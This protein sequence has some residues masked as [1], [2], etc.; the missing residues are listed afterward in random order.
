MTQPEPV[1]NHIPDLTRFLTG[2]LHIDF[3]ASPLGGQIGLTH[4]PGRNQVDA[5]GRIWSRDLSLDLDA[6]V[7]AGVSTL[8]TFLDQQELNRLGAAKLP[9]LVRSRP[10]NWVQ[11][12]IPD[13]GVPTDV[14]LLEWCNLLGPMLNQLRNNEQIL[15]HCAAGLGRSGMMAATLLKACGITSD[16]A[17]RLIRQNRSGTV[18]TVEQEKF[19]HKFQYPRLMD[20]A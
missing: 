7:S 18:E 3:V 8:I 15:L 12:P 1:C 11:L 2:P 4:C 16:D 9:T 17:I 5:R 6:I 13:F 20:H 14:I 10:F 19:I